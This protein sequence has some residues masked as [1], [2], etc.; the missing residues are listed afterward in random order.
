MWLN[1]QGSQFNDESTNTK[2]DNLGNVYLCGYFMGTIDVDPSS[3]VY[4]LISNGQQDIF[5]IKYDSQNNLLWA[6]SIGGAGNDVAYGLDVNSSGVY[7]S[8][9]FSG[10]NVDFDNSINTSLLSSN[11]SE[12]CFIAKFDLS[13]NYVFAKSFGGIGK[14]IVTD[15]VVSLDGSVNIIGVYSSNIDIDPDINVFNIVCEGLTDVFFAKFNQ[16]G[17]FDTGFTF[18][19]TGS[20]NAYKL[21]IDNSNDVFITGSFSSTLCDFDPTNSVFQISSNGQADIYLSKYSNAGLLLW[22]N[23]IGGSN[24]DFGRSIALDS[25]NSIFI[26]ADFTDDTVDVLPGVGIVNVLNRGGTDFLLCK[27]NRQTGSLIWGAGIGGSGFDTGT[28]IKVKGDSNIVV[29]GAFSG[30][31]VNF[32]PSGFSTLTS[33]GVDVFQAEYS[34]NGSLISVFNVGG[35][36]GEVPNAICLGDVNEI[37]M[38][39]KFYSSPSDFD[40]SVNNTNTLCQGNHDS[41]LAKYSV[42]SLDFKQISIDEKLIFQ[43]PN[44]FKNYFALDLDPLIP[45]VSVKLF[46]MEGKSINIS[47]VDNQNGKYT[48]LVPDLVFGLYMLEVFS[49][50]KS[51]Y[52]KKII[53]RDF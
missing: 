49:A 29:C 42:I 6:N 8:G 40:P 38:C 3:S 34:A 39:G 47:L 31:N 35:N 36:S 15:L 21:Q 32:D 16:N 50:N 44:P 25:L 48:I 41:F 46:N 10:T 43:Y 37:Y 53:Y 17:L 45:E 23:T 52:K 13:G 2:I 33:Q 28:D 27:Y 7:V 12:D 11:G 30:T 14:D 19:G 18:G 5:L 26:L 1:T 22:V 4:N 9:Y 24:D 20:E 51:L